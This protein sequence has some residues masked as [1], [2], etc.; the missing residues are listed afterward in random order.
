MHACTVQEWLASTGEIV[1]SFALLNLLGV[2]HLATMLRM[3]PMQLTVEGS[4]PTLLFKW[5]QNQLKEQACSSCVQPRLHPCIHS[6][7][8]P[9]VNRGA[10][11]RPLIKH[12][13]VS[14]HTATFACISL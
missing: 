12:R 8:L 1:D 14:E 13:P 6:P 11:P 4:E 3:Q 9:P 2:S 5:H 7:T 10:R